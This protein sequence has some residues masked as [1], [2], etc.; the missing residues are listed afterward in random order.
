MN[1]TASYPMR[2]GGRFSG[3][4]ARPER[5]TEINRVWIGHIW[6]RTGYK[7]WDT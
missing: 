5:D 4:K 1:A 6:L 7:W 2:N 3:G